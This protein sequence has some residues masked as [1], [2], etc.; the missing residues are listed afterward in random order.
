MPAASEQQVTEMAI[1]S[2]LSQL[3]LVRDKLQDIGHELGVPDRRLSE[4]LVAVDELL[5]NVV[6][7]AWSEETEVDPARRQIAVRIVSGPAQIEVEFVDA[8]RAFDPLAT[9]APQPR[10][11]GRRPRPGGVGLQIL[12]KLVD[13]IYYERIDGLNRTRMIKRYGHL[14]GEAESEP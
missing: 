14:D 5:S 8:G 1:A 9:P 7:Y 4:L 11:A 6:K 2:Q 3:G 10:V 13:E 12:K